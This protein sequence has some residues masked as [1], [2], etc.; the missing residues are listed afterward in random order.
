MPRQGGG[1]SCCYYYV[2]QTATLQLLHQALPN[3][4]SMTHFIAQNLHVPAHTQMGG[5]NYRFLGIQI[6]SKQAGG[7]SCSASCSVLFCYVYK[8]VSTYGQGEFLLSSG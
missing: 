6:I 7:C 2:R 4:K 1:C 8:P 3:S 5:N